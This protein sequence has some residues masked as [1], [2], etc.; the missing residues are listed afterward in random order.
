MRKDAFFLGKTYFC[1]VKYPLYVAMR[2]ACEV[3]SAIG[4]AKVI[5]DISMRM[6]AKGHEVTLY[7]CRRCCKGEKREEKNEEGSDSSCL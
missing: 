6:A 3:F 2:A 4:L 5:H 1:I 7:N